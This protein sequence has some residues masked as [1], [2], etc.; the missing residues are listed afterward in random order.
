VDDASDLLTDFMA[1]MAAEAL[2]LA[3]ELTERI[4]RGP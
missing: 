2:K 4:G 3:G 1:H